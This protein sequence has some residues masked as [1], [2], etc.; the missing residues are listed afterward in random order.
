MSRTSI[1]IVNP[2]GVGAKQINR[3]GPAQARFRARIARRLAR[4][5]QTQC[6]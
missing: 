4:Q 3:S 5:Q 2:V 1:E 6:R